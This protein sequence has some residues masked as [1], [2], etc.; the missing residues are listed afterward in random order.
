[1]FS[2]ILRF[3][4]KVRPYGM[5]TT[6]TYLAPQK[7]EKPNF[8]SVPFL[9]FFFW[10]CLSGHD[11]WIWICGWI[12]ASYL[13]VWIPSW[14]ISSKLPQ[15]QGHC[16]GLHTDAYTMR[17]WYLLACVWTSCNLDSLEIELQLQLPKLLKFMT[18]GLLSL[19]GTV[20][21]CPLKCCL[22]NS[23]L[24]MRGNGHSNHWM[25]LCWPLCALATFLEHLAK[26]MVMVCE[27]VWHGMAP[28]VSIW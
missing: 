12:D 6:K 17:L 22:R 16:Q 11:G 27:C 19:G 2:N 23:C 21:H 9:F 15:F 10:R 20:W 25:A 7:L 5:F 26:Q 14:E 3:C 28:C 8:T 1:M 24:S 13:H 18:T 4:V